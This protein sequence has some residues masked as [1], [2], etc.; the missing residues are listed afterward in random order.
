[1]MEDFNRHE[2]IDTSR[3]KIRTALVRLLADPSLGRVLLFEH[4]GATAGYAVLTF[5]YDLEFAGRD[6]FLT[7]LYLVPSARGR[8]LGRPAIAAVEVEARAAGV[9]AIHLVVRTDNVAARRLYDKTGFECPPRVLM[10]K[11]LVEL[12]KD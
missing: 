7:E 5:G 6:A 3:A 8:G 10:S 9:N 4:D 2:E 12:T 1:M 11:P